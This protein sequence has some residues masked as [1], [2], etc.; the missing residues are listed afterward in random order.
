M[1]VKKQAIMP[2]YHMHMWYNKKVITNILFLSNMIKQYQVTYDSNDQVF[3]VHC[4]P[5]G[6][7][8]MEFWMHESKL[9]YF[10]PTE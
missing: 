5:E 2:G 6:K 4:K 3:V 8:D 1:E 7:P 10:N 9:H